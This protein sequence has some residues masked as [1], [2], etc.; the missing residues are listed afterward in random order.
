MFPYTNQW[1]FNMISLPSKPEWINKESFY[2]KK[3]T[4]LYINNC[5]T[6]SGTAVYTIYTNSFNLRILF[7]IMLNNWMFF[8]QV[9]RARLRES[10]HRTNGN[11]IKSRIKGR[12]QRRVYNVEGVNH[13]WHID[14]HHKLIRWNFII[15]GGIDG[16]SRFITFLNCTDNN[17]SET[18]FSCF[19]CAIRNYGLPLRVR[20]DKRLENKSVAEYKVRTR[21]PNRGIMITG[22]S[23]HNQR[24]ES[25]I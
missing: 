22:K 5:K 14:T 11:N 2:I 23:F 21:G 15:V 24:I 7:H 9:T 19:Q 3:K 8:K 6:W 18:I 10:L 4:Q 13:L 12:L 20:S 1:N 17:K 16:F 25:P